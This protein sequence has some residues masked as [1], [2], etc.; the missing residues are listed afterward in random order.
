MKD[1]LP[2]KMTWFELFLRDRKGDPELPAASFGID[3]SA[4]DE[5]RF[6]FHF[7]I[8]EA[9]VVD[10]RLIVDREDLALPAVIDGDG[11]S[12]NG[13]DNSVKC[14]NFLLGDDFARCKTQA[15]SNDDES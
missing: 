12:V 10:R 2:E 11:V 4:N 5:A 1:T 8:Q 6:D 3:T 13:F 15:E 7:R 9:D 14:F